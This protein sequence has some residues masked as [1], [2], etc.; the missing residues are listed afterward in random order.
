MNGLKSDPSV[1]WSTS[2]ARHFNLQLE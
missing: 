1:S 2:P